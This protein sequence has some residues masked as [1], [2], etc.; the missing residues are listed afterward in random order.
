MAIRPGSFAITS[1]LKTSLTWPISLETRIWTPSL[2][3]IPALSCPRCCNAYRPRYASFDASGWPKMPKTPHSSRN[4]S[5]MGLGEPI[6][7]GL[8]GDVAVLFE[9]RPDRL[10]PDLF[11]IRE[12]LVDDHA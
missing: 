1:S 10:G 9:V 7:Y 6:V 5:N 11:G 2:A 8:S 4:L 12:P 3:A